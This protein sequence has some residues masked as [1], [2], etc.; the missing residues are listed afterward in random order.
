MAETDPAQHIA[1]QNVKVLLEDNPFHYSIATRVRNR[2]FLRYLDPQPGERVLDVGCGV[3]Y[4]VSLLRQSGACIW[5]VDIDLSSIR[6]A[7][8]TIGGY[9]LVARGEQLPF[10]DGTFDKL[11]CS[12]VLE[13][14]ADD[15]HA[16]A[17][18]QRVAKVGATVVITVPSPDG[19]FGAR[20]KSICHGGQADDCWEKHHREG[21]SR[22]E[23]ISLL[24]RCNIQVESDRYTLVFLA[25][26][27]MGMTKLAFAASSKRRRLESQSQVLQTKR[28]PL[29]ALYRRVFPLLLLLS[30][31]E[32]AILARILRGHM[33]IVK[34]VIRE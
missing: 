24:E 14:I 15:A 34:G 10:A 26:I 30:R 23:L 3:G 9:F 6:S 8:Q 31:I 19:V 32:D 5:G 17:E 11:L 25:E 2:Y 4:F 21:Y 12:E 29:L 1:R 16:V 22:D 33:L 28:S 27:L 7:I 18:L 20:I 13:H